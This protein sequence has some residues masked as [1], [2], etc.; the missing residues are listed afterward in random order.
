MIHFAASGAR[1]L[2]LPVALP[3]STRQTS[4]TRCGALAGVYVT[5]PAN[6]RRQPGQRADCEHTA[7]DADTLT[8]RMDGRKATCRRAGENTPRLSDALQVR[9]DRVG[10]YGPAAPRSSTR[11]YIG[12]L[13]VAFPAFS[14]CVIT[15]VF[16]PGAARIH[17]GVD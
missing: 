9:R 5:A 13:G 7:Q 15:G 11:N 17:A 3:L 1:S 14:P 6:D 2:S 12:R 16:P 4:P 10:V 8:D